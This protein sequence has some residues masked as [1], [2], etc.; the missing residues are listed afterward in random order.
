MKNAHLF[1]LYFIGVAAAYALTVVMITAP[2]P[3]ATAPQ[4][5]LD[6]SYGETP[7]PEGHGK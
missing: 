3:K 5:A 4:A 6:A 7:K 1:L 2:V